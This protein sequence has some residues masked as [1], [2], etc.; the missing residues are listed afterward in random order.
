MN[1]R[2]PSAAAI[3]FLALSLAGS[4]PA[5]NPTASLRGKAVKPDGKPLSNVSILVSSPSF[6]GQAAYLTGASGAFN[7]LAL[8]PGVYDLRADLPGH[9]SCLR[10]GLD[11][12][13]GRTL[14]LRIVL[15][16]SELEEDEAAT[17]P[18]PGLD[19]LSSK[20]GLVITQALLAAL[21]LGRDIRDLQAL[22]PGA[23]AEDRPYDRAVS[24][25]GGSARGQAAVLDGALMND[26]SSG[27]PIGNLNVDIIDQ[28]EIIST[29]KPAAEESGRGAII[30]LVSR[31]G[32]NRFSGSLSFHSAGE[33]LSSNGYDAAAV[34]GLAL[35]P[36]DRLLR[37]RDFSLNLGGPLWEDRAWYFL[38]ARRL[39]SAWPNPYHPGARLAGMT[40]GDA[41]LFDREQS[42]WMVFLKTTVNATGRIRYTG[43]F[44]WN[45]LYQ[46]VDEASIAPDTALDATWIRDHENSYATS[47]HVTL[48]LTPKVRV[49]IRGTYI[50]RD[51]P[52]LVRDDIQYATV[53]FSRQVTW[54]SAPYNLKSA[55][56]RMSGQAGLTAYL[57]RALGAEH[58]IRATAGIEQ[59]DSRRDWWKAN[60]YSSMWYDYAAGNPY[61]VDPAR[62]IG[63][64]RIAAGPAGESFWHLQDNIRRFSAS[65]E[66]GIRA[67]RLAL[68]LGLRFDFSQDILP[69]QSRP[70]LAYEYAPENI[71]SDL[72]DNDLLEALIKRVNDA[73]LLTPFNQMTIYQ[74]T[75]VSFLTFAPRAGLSYD[76]F[77]DGSTALKLSFARDYESLWT[78]LYGAGHIFNPRYA[79]WDWYDLNGDKRM[80]LPGTDEYV[81]VSALNQDPTVSLFEYTD[82]FGVERKAE[83]PRSDLFSAS[84]EREVVPGFTV[85]AQFTL[86]RTSN[87]LSLIDIENGYDP[88]ARDEKGLIWLPF[89]V[90]DPG[91]DAALGTSDDRSLTVYGLRRDRPAPDY[92][93]AN[94]PEAEQ[95]YT[96]G[97]LTFEKRLSRG[98]QMA[99]SF[100]FS[101]F[102]GNLGADAAAAGAATSRFTDPNGLTNS[103]GKLWLDRPIQVRLMAGVRLPYGFF[104]GGYFRYLSGAPTGRSL[105]RVYF[106]EDYMGFGTHAPYV[107]V[108]AA[109]LGAGREPA[110]SSLDM[111]LQRGFRVGRGGKLDLYL[112]V[113][114]L[115]GSSALIEDTDPAGVLR[116]DQAQATYTV[117]PSYG[118]ILSYYGVRT[119]RIGAKLNF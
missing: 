6:Q 82:G 49:E 76:L 41:S 20:G 61:Y 11:L 100:T 51:V 85:G 72:S 13:A 75:N 117:S 119:I 25:Q 29:G 5:Q 91:S 9:K 32:G 21:P 80:D 86:R 15:E 7:F 16:P 103:D 77:G 38:N 42:E 95:R 109:A 18:L 33:A 12:R 24:I 63:R 8:P 39:S 70:T 23:V 111:R 54:G 115:L 114:N 113:F 37:L 3:L 30:H 88:T 66:D 101:S 26:P 27:F 46:P 118:S 60:P 107:T 81:L 94:I 104:L 14:D 116:S 78:G 69:V 45:N 59:A 44:H 102:K 89:T 55:F 10:G 65:L 67:G 17:S 36:S 22:A 74:K 106:P 53:D 84:L 2:T 68:N 83:A 56:K 64:L 71:A 73:D 97:I 34:E 99:G 87:L 35:A 79:E 40:Q 108:A 57:G 62:S 31:S 58:V 98:W 90:T 93:Y 96:A 19:A 4:L 110:F 28:V 105:A 48:D 92:R 52:Q 47:H 50:E 112:D 43:S 1:R